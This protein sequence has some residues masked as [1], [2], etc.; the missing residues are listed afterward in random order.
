ML[1]GPRGNTLKK[2]ENESGAKFCNAPITPCRLA[3]NDGVRASVRVPTSIAGLSAGNARDNSAVPGA[4]RWDG[5]SIA[6][7]SSRCGSLSI[8]N[9][10]AARKVSKRCQRAPGKDLFFSISDLDGG[11]N[12][13]H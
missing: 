8:M 4:N 9:R 1:I 12:G 11:E 2:M 3:S 5:G 6:S 10:S 13:S 7:P